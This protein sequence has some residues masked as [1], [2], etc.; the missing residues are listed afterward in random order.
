MSEL[1]HETL[2][3]AARPDDPS[4]A[5][6]NTVRS[7][8]GTAVAF[9]R[10]GRGAPLILVDGALCHRS[11]G[12]STPLA[13]LLAPH[14]TVFTYD[15]RGRGDSGDSAPYGV[16]REIEDL[17]A[18]LDEAGGAAY[19]WGISSGA[20]LAL[21]ATRRGLAVTKLAL[22]EAPFIVDDSRPRIPADIVSQLTALVAAD[23]RGDAV[24][25]FLRHMGAPAI[26]IALIR[27][28]PLWKKLTQIAHTL[29]YDMTIV[30]PY[31]AGTPLPAHR[32]NDVTIPALVMVGAKS[33]AWVHHSMQAL[34][35]VLPNAAHRVVQRQTHNVKAKALAPPLEEFFNH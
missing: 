30:G 11:M 31:Q 35:D 12:P 18:L 33:P 4:D 14:F 6:V 15:R 22:Y 21:E 19:V 3:A 9:E 1:V 8:D 28:L 2:T 26:A 34:A 27:H 32:W 24:R 13:A 20:A 23:R 29:P 17:Q 5:S 10:V 7:R 16:D 25:L